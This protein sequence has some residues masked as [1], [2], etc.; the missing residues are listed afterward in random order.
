[1]KKWLLLAIYGCGAVPDATLRIPA[2]MVSASIDPTQLKSYKLWVLQQ[3][4]RDNNPIQ[5]AD[6]LSREISPADDNALKVLDPI[7]GNF[8]STLT[9]KSIVN[10]VQ[11]RIFY[12]DLFDAPAGQIGQRIGAGCTASVTI[13]GGKTTKLEIDISPPPPPVIPP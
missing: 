5:C 13:A 10:G 8:A 4:G 3:V 7:T 9:V 2:Q 12:I 1:M 6:L 11:D